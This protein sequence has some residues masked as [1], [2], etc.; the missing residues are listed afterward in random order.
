MTLSLFAVG[1]T[2]RIVHGDASVVL[3]RLPEGSVDAIVTDPPSAIGFMGAEWDG[4]HGGRDKWVR[5]LADIL[6]AGRRALKPG[7]HALVW[8]LPKTSHWTG[9]AIEDAGF[10]IRDRVTHL[11]GEGMPKSPHVLKPAAEDWWLARNPLEGTARENIAKHGTGGLNI[12]A[13]RIPYA[14]DADR[15]QAIVPQPDLR[16]VSGRST[17]LD[18]HARNGQM[19]D[20]KGGRWPANATLD[21]AAAREL[22]EQVGMLRSGSMAAGTPRGSNAV[23]GKAPRSAACSVDI[24][25]STG[26]ASRFF[27]VAK[28]DEADRTEDGIVENDHET[29]KSVALMRWLVRLVTPP[30]GLVLDPFAGSGTT[31]IACAAEGLSFVGI[32]QSEKHHRTAQR[33]L[34]RWFGNVGTELSA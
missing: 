9:T 12:D 3:R 14:S 1:R 2:A 21:E 15:E 32:E 19:F 33:R 34:Q 30:G 17:K 18:A 23:F 4:D 11:F 24:I 16:S 31:G 13:C 10:E 28:A 20:P 5:W 27:Y 7:A 6:G 22:D 25:G 29:V 8:S 26:G